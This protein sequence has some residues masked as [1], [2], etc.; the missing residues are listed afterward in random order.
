MKPL[1]ALQLQLRLEGFEIVSGNRLRQVEILPDEEMPLMILTQLADGP[2]VPYFDESLDLGLYQELMDQTKLIQFPDIDPLINV[3]NMQNIPFRVGHYKTSLFPT[4]YLNFVSNEVER[5]SREDPQVQHFGFGEFAEQVYAITRDGKIV[6]ACVS[7]REDTGCG[8]AWVC[9]DPQYRHRGLARQ[10][11][12]AWAR[13]MLAA[14]KVPF[15]SHKIDNTASAGLAGRL[16][17]LPAFEE[18]VISYAD[19]SSPS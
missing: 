16:G 8:E 3:L 19:A 11:V 12:S 10:V 2:V 7:T 17:L 6:S 14:G 9:T 15:Y 4:T 1:E 18:I 5:Y 13:E